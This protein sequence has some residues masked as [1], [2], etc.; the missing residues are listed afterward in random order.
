MR[1]IG[2]YDWKSLD[3]YDTRHQDLCDVAVHLPYAIK[4]TGNGGEKG[5]LPHITHVLDFFLE[6]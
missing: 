6:H 3:C 1:Y 2:L 5:G 4:A